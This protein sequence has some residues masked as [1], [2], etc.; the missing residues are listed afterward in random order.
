MARPGTFPPG[1]SGNPGGRPRGLR[2]E[3][4]KHIGDNGELVAETL[5]RLVK[6]RNER[7]QLEA[8]RLLAE[9]AGFSRAPDT[10]VTINAD[11]LR[12][13]SDEELQIALNVAERL[14]AA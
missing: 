3:I 1:V 12:E 13:L 14:S 7:V 9:Y 10:T 4:R 11:A 8:C 6:S 5:V 2:S